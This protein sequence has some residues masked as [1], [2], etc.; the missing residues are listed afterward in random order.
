MTMTVV[1]GRSEA[2]AASEAGSLAGAEGSAGPMPSRPPMSFPGVQ[3]MWEPRRGRF[4]RIHDVHHTLFREDGS[5]VVRKRMKTRE[6]I[7][8]NVGALCDNVSGCPFGDAMHGSVVLVVRTPPFQGGD[9]R[10]EPGRSYHK[11]AGRRREASDLFCAGDTGPEARD[12][13]LPGARCGWAES[14]WESCEPRSHGPA[15]SGSQARKARAETLPAVS[16]QVRAAE[17]QVAGRDP[18]SSGCGPGSRRS[19]AYKLGTREPSSGG[20][21]ACKARELR[22]CQPRPC[23]FG[24]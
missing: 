12:I 24:S 13:G 9:R 14:S 8:A 6:I 21:Q 1:R 20:P 22:T 15:S 19:Q 7:L 16:P 5:A 18:A 17:L 23:K 10:F 11:Q 2:R 3:G 4:V